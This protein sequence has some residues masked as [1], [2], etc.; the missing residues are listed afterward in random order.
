MENTFVIAWKDKTG[1][2]RGRGRKL[3]SKDEAEELAKELNREYP[4]FIHEAV[5]T[6]SESAVEPAPEPAAAESF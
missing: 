6:D 5:N 2:R 4:N 3:L 1:E